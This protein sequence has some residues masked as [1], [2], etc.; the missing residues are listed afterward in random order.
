[1]KRADRFSKKLK[2]KLDELVPSYEWMPNWRLGKGH[3][4][5]DVAGLSRQRN[6]SHQLVFVE[7]ELRRGHPVANIVKIWKWLENTSKIRRLV[8]FHAF[9]KFYTPGHARRINAEFIGRQIQEINPRFRYVCIGI[10]YMPR[11]KGRSGGR[12]TRHHAEGLAYKIAKKL[13]L[14]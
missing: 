13:R 14:D 7:A 6:R 4:N 8:V 10:P 9:S 1:M 3:E 2:R 11:K 5:V 12:R